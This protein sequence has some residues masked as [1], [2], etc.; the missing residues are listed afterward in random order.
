MDNFCIAVYYRPELTGRFPERRLGLLSS[1]L[2]LERAERVLSK[3]L[4]FAGALGA[5]QELRH[6]PVLGS[7]VRPPFRSGVPAIISNRHIDAVVNEK[8]CC[9]IVLTDGAFVQDASWLMRAP[10]GIDVGSA[11][12]QERRN[13]KMPVH[14]RPGQRYVQYVL[15]VGGGPMQV[16]QNG[17]IVGRVMLTETP[18]PRPAGLIKPTPDSREVP[19]SGRV[20]EIIGQRPNRRQNRNEMRL[21]IFQSEH[22]RGRRRAPHR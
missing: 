2:G 20:A 22:Q 6:G 7:V 3:G 5:R 11:L 15:R 18:Q 1:R 21:P 14:A 12:Q 13:L 17:T 9:F 10:V 19:Y 16:S 8:L 4:C